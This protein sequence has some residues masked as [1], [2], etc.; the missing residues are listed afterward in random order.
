MND[1]GV[2]EQVPAGEGPG[3]RERLLAAAAGLFAD[4]GYA[5]TSVR[6]ICEAAGVTKPTLYYYFGSKGGLARALLGDAAENLL[7][8]LEGVASAPGAPREKLKAMARLIFER[9]SEAPQTCRFFYASFLGPREAVAAYDFDAVIPRIITLTARVFREGLQAGGGPA[10]DCELA[11]MILL[12]ALQGFA[13]RFVRR[14][15][16]QLTG[17]LADQIVDQVLSG[18]SAESPDRGRAI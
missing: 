12:G 15:D 13:M 3:S 1:S 18:V 4:R 17:D 8:G 16:I 9:S 7:A 2:P 10:S 14:Q 5:A 6:E 11:A